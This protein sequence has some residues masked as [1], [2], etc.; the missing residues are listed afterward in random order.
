MSLRYKAWLCLPALVYI[1]LAAYWHCRAADAAS[2]DE[3]H[4]LLLAESMVEDFD[5]N[6]QNNLVEAGIHCPEYKYSQSFSG[7]HGWFS[8]HNLGLPAL[9]A[10]PWLFGGAWGARLMMAAC[11]GF[12]A[13]AIYAVISHVWK[14][15]NALLMTMALAMGMPLVY[16]CHQIYPDLLSGILLL[17]V[18]GT[19]MTAVKSGTRYEWREVAVSLALAFL[20]W[21]HIKYSAPA[22]VAFAWYADARRGKR[23]ALVAAV[24][25]ASLAMLVWYNVYAFGKPTGPYSDDAIS[26]EHN[27]LVVLLGLHVDQAQGMFAQQP[28]WLLGVFGLAPMWRASRKACCWWLLLYASVIV[29]NALHPCW[30]GGG[31]YIGR[32]GSNGALLWSIPL[33]YGARELFAESRLGP[34]L[35]AGMAGSLQVLMASIWLNDARP[36]YGYSGPE[37]VWFCNSVY[38]SPLKSFLP[39]WVPEAHCWSYPP[40]WSALVLAAGTLLWGAFWRCRV[41]FVRR[42]LAATMIA[43]AALSAVARVKPAPMTWNGGALAGWVGCV[44][45]TCRVAVD[46]KAGKGAL[47]ETPRIFPPAGNYRVC[48][49]YQARGDKDHLGMVMYGNGERF[50]ILSLLTPNNGQPAQ[51]ISRLEVSRGESGKQ[52]SVFVWYEGQGNL[53]VARLSVERLTR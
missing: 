13:P 28:L 16:A 4:Y 24:L 38:P 39:Y 5:V 15:D 43:A 21:L 2:A 11:C 49:D 6:V 27:S 17:F 53:S 32:F 19:A 52:S 9:L 44:E 45:G 10:A 34:A 25:A 20:P 22:L 35:A 29:P 18:A 36:R 48:V 30:Y 37:S 12:A 31:S 51:S 33:A 1:A 26:F 46:G 14:R 42:A 47:A 50:R 40:N 7:A 8:I 3:T 41:P 23:C